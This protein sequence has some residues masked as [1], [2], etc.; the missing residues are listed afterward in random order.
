MKKGQGKNLQISNF[1]EIVI[2][3]NQVGGFL[4]SPKTTKWQ[5]QNFERGFLKACLLLSAKQRTTGFGRG[6]TFHI[7]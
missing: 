5:F 2:H 4:H 1:E 7:E 6:T 3:K